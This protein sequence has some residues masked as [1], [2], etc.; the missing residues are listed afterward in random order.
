MINQEGYFYILTN[1][2]NNVLYSGSTK[3][4]IKR[5]EEHRRGYQKGFA[6]KY[7]IN[8]LIY[9]EIF[10]HI[11]KA[12]DRERQVKGWTRSRKIELI[13]LKNKQ[14]EDLY[15]EL[16]RDPSLLPAG[17]SLRMRANIKRFPDPSN[18]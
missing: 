9:H 10:K 15:D 17:R 14:W 11:D 12:K 4:I 18:I 7:N 16:F 8:R 3:N 5:I 13:E 1:K 6:Y 2:R